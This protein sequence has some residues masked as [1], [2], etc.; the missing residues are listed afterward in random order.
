MGVSRRGIFLLVL[1]RAAALGILAGLLAVVAGFGIE[2]AL[3]W[4]P[5]P[6]TVFA[7]WK[8]T[9]SIQVGPLDVAIVIAGAILCAAIGAIL[10]AFRASRIDP[11]DAIV[12]GRF[13]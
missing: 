7:D 9:V 13:T 4:T 11:F 8:P 1:A 5:P 3:A 12:E 10:P 2:Q 6:G